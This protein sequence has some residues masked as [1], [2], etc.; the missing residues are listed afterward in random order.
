MF[1]RH[2]NNRPLLFHDHFSQIILV[3][4]NIIATQSVVTMPTAAYLLGFFVNNA[5]FSPN[6]PK[7]ALL[8]R[9]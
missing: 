5:V 3:C 6:I 2:S 9:S 4:G 1:G 8:L 7:A